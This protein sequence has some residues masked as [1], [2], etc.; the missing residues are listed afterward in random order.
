MEEAEVEEEERFE[1]EYEESSEEDSNRKTGT[2][3]VIEIENPN[4]ATLKT[5]KAR[6]ADVAQFHDVDEEDFEFSLVNGD[7]HVSAEDTASEAKVYNEEDACSDSLGKLFINERE[8]SASASS[9]EADESE[10]RL[11]LIRQQRAK[12]AKKRDDEKAAKD[13]KKAEA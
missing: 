3:G 11:A 2:Q 12:V 9:S 8:E 4:V 13:Q 10:K 5:L 7:E 6:D 1:E